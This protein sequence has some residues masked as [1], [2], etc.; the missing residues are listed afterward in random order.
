MN[1]EEQAAFTAMTEQVAALT[2]STD[3]MAAKNQELLAETKKA[4][5]DSKAAQDAA[6][7]EN[8]N[9]AKAKGDY[10][11]LHKSSEE[12]RK[13]LESQLE[14]LRGGIATEK[15]T[16]AAMKM[17]SELAEG[18]NAEL[19][20]EFIGR[21]LRYTD[22]GIKVLDSSGDSTIATVDDL[23]KEFQSDDKYGSLLSGN[24]STGG[25]ASGS[26][27]SGGAAVKEMN[28]ADFEKLNPLKRMEF[29]KSGGITTD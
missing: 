9:K 6:L 28:R 8:E 12:G 26:T 15:K 4:K 10:E 2:K 18:S 13:S 19:L 27:D 25:S 14:T 16:N 24:K 5:G 22:D 1:E 7:L 29:M 3:S 11:Q 21:R 20:S 23:K 17:A